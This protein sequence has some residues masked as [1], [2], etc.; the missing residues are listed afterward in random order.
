MKNEILLK[1]VSLATKVVFA[2]L[3][4]SI[5]LSILFPNY[6]PISQKEAASWIN[7]QQYDKVMFV[8]LQI[9]QVIVPPISHYFTSILGGYIYGPIYGGLLNWIGRVIGQFIAFYIA[10]QAGAW[11]RNKLN[12]DFTP[13][14]KLVGGGG[15]N[16][17][18]RAWIILAMIA[19]PFF[20]D[21]ELS[22]AMGFAKFPFWL[23]SLITIVGH[24]LGSFALAFLGSGK[25]FKGL[26]FIT[27]SAITIVSFIIL[28]IASAK[29]R[30]RKN[31]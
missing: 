21:D 6:F 28:V 15:K 12:W 22:Y 2:L 29:V 19:L 30:N 31:N 9:F 27:L 14:E 17:S 26:L 5:L 1:K 24:L 11:M 4:I 25:D 16:I 7:A 10:L 23:F 13:F 3:A 8:F 20:P 18:L